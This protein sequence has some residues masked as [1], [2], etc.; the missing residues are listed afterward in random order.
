MKQEWIDH[1]NQHRRVWHCHSH[2]AEF[3]TQP[4]YLQHVK[5]Q[6]ADEKWE[7]YTSETIAA[8]VGASAKPHRDCPFCPTA[9]SDVPMMQKHV[10]YHLERL[11]LYALPD[12]GEDKDEELASEGSLDSHR[13]IKHRGR[14]DSI[15]ND[16]AEERQAWRA[17]LVACNKGGTTKNYAPLTTA[18][19]QLIEQRSPVP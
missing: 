13:V 18:N 11:A 16:F 15:N 5:E 9:F 14:Q 6:H 10:R 8:V 4:E 2:E 19:L 12:I 7:Y 17:F 3:E 1:E